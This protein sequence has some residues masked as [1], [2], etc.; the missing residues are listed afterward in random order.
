MSAALAAAR[1]RR[2]PA[3]AIPDPVPTQVQPQQNASGL[4]LPQVIAVV[5]SRLTVL[6][7]FM[8]SQ[9][10]TTKSTE[11]ISIA[12]STGELDDIVNEFN[13]RYTILAEE[14]ENI[15]NIVLNL[16]S[17]TMNVNKTLLEERVHVLSEITPPQGFVEKTDNLEQIQEFSLEEI[18]GI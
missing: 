9:Q 2:A 13:S 7:K 18:N 17:Y 14:I 6:E 15:K 16:Q 1:K 3:S 5:D 10:E 8:K 11:N 4:T 12:P